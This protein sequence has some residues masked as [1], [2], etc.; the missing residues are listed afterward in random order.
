MH[1]VS[2]GNQILPELNYCNRCGARTG[3][4]GPK[5]KPINP[6]SYL[7]TALC[8]IGGG[9]LLLLVGLIAIL[10]DEHADPKAVVIISA[11]YLLAL[12]GINFMI[13]RQISRLITAQI[14]PGKDMS[15]KRSY[16]LHAHHTNQLEAPRQPVSSVTDHTTRTLDEVLLK[17]R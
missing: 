3:N 14:G 15:E 12:F 7:I 16:E 5:D 11:L 17:E 10:L 8:I 6:L 2:C 13:I 9:G 4:E 1:C